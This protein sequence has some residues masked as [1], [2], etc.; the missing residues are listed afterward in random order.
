MKD[1]SATPPVLPA[2][3]QSG[4]PTVHATKEVGGPLQRRRS[5]LPTADQAPR[6]QTRAEIP[7][8]LTG[9]PSNQH[10]S[11]PAN[12][13]PDMAA[14]KS[15][16]AS[17]GPMPGAEHAGPAGAAPST[18]PAHRSDAGAPGD[19]TSMEAPTQGSPQAHAECEAHT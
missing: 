2:E 12:R 6:G 15:S 3:P 11:T 17:E 9:Q 8:G 19:A 5:A 16:E 7:S 10:A 14:S 1:D 18:A 13:P 4:G